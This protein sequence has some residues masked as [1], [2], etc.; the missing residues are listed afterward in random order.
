MSGPELDHGP[1]V[2]RMCVQNGRSACVRAV[3]TCATRH[4]SSRGSRFG[5]EQ[6]M[7]L[8][9]SAL[10]LTSGGLSD[11]RMGSSQMLLSGKAE[12]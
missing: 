1:T 7:H 5:A 8:I 6:L 3:S 11:D 9:S 4:W 2:L 10:R 12:Y